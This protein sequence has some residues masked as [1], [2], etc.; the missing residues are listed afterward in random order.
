MRAIEE[1]TSLGRIIAVVIIG[2]LT[3]SL[4]VNGV[5]LFLAG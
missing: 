2:L 5:R 1:A 4:L 3:C